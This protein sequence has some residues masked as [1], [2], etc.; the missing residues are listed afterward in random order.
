MGREV[1]GRKT[2]CYEVFHLD[3]ERRVLENGVEMLANLRKLFVQCQHKDVVKYL[4]TVFS[5]ACI[6]NW[7]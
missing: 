7:K 4:R 5:S 2:S 1:V 3:A 6:M